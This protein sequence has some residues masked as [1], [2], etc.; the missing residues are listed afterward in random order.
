MV[1]VL[2]QQDVTIHCRAGEMTALVGTS[3]SGKLLGSGKLV[4]V[5]Q[6]PK[7]QGPQEPLFT[8]FSFLG[9]FFEL[10]WHWHPL[11]VFRAWWLRSSLINLIQSFY[12]V[13]SGQA[14]LMHHLTAMLSHFLTSQ[15]WGCASSILNLVLSTIFADGLDELIWRKCVFFSI[16]IPSAAK[17][18]RFTFGDLGVEK[19]SLDVAFAFATVRN[20]PQPSAARPQ[21]VPYGRAYSHCCKSDHCFKHRVSSFRVAGVELGT[22]W[23]CNMFHS[24]SKVILCDRLN[25][26]EM[27]F[28]R[29]GAFFVAGAALWRPPS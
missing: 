3:G 25:T 18:S 26:F 29:W 9:N 5:Q 28:R 20:R 12:S 27:I 16:F 22:S 23:H 24:S 10:G 6:K 1:H 13:Q 14:H 8:R 2:M 4:H 7:Y 15:S 19:R 11:V 21:V 17:G